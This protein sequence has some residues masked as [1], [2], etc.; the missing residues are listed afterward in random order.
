MKA[1]VFY[2]S[3]A[4]AT[5]DKIMEVYPR[6]KARVDEFAEAGRVIAIGPFGNPGEGSMGIFRDMESAEEFVK[7]DPFVLEG[8]VA[9]HTIKLW[10]DDLL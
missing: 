9:K 10:N 3:A 5:M 6:H 1:V 4:D 7:D 8:I 2:E